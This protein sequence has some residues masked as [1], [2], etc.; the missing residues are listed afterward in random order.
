[1]DEEIKDLITYEVEKLGL[2]YIQKKIT[3]EELQAS[4]GAIIKKY[5][6]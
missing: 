4:V 2:D 6:P 5:K 1:M 3:K